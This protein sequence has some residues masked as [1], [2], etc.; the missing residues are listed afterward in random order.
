MPAAVAATLLEKARSDTIDRQ[1]KEDS[2]K[3]KDEFKVLLLG[4]SPPKHPTSR[5]VGTNLTLS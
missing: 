1:L 2:R 5:A 3:V 4:Q